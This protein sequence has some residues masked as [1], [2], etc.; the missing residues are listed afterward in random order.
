MIAL[1]VS[2]LI[3]WLLLKMLWPRAPILEP[4]PPQVVVHVHLIVDPLSRSSVGGEHWRAVGF[5]VD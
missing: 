5:V 3:G 4:P 1:I 2:L